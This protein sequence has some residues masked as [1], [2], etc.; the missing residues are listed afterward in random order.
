MNKNQATLATQRNY[1][2]T[3]EQH[4][5]KPIVGEY[6]LGILYPLHLSD[7]DY[8]L[9][10]CGCESPVAQP[11][12]IMMALTK[13]VCC[14]R[15]HWSNVLLGFARRCI[16]QW[17]SNHAKAL[18]IQSLFTFE[19][20]ASLSSKYS[21]Y[22]ISAT[23]P[24]E[25]YKKAEACFWTVEEIDLSNDPADWQNLSDNERFFIKH[26]LAFFA[27]SD[28]IVNENLATEFMQLIECQESSAFMAFK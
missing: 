2:D 6:G 25:M 10:R 21:L 9:H 13:L 1:H 20:P 16:K 26:V 27:D 17:A 23:Q 22:P 14:L 15:W 11:T 5:R 7:S 28:G 8:E 4:S 12:Q 19:S 24:W 3:A 18:A